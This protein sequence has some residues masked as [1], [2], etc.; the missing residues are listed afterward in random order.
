MRPPNIDFMRRA[1]AL[2]ER[3]RWSVS[4]NPMVGCVIV[5]D[6]L[7]I[8]EGWHQRA[9]EPHAEIEAL[10]NCPDARGATMYVTLEPCAHHGRTPP[11]VDAIIAAGIARVVIAMRDP[12][13]LAAGGIEKLR[14][15]GVSTEAGVLEDDARKLNEVFIHAVT[16]DTPFVVL[17][18]GMTLD[19]KLGTASRESKWITSPAAREKSLELREQYDAILAGAGTIR[20]D[21]PQLTRRLGKATTPWTR[22]ILDRSRIV[23]AGAT[24]LTDGGTTLHITED[25]DLEQLLRDLHARGIR[26]L[27]VEGGSA[28]HAEFLRR[29]LWQKLIVFIAPLVA[30]GNG[31]SIYSGEP[32][33]RLADAHRFRFESAELVGDDVMLTAVPR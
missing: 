18:A 33:A 2:A 7:V 9:G 11:C 5:R 28:I 21:N 20:D 10:R 31:P 4:P 25:V 17:K 14:A 24:V 3:G 1:L 15:A 26:S 19:A 27:L 12:H 8:A 32:L 30:G 6:D 23:P 13:E 22:V 29:Q 16:H